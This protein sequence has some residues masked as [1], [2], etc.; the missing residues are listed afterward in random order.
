MGL[1]EAIDRFDP[2]KGREFYQFAKAR[3][4]GA[5]LDEIRR[6]YGRDDRTKIKPYYLDDIDCDVQDT[7]YHGI[8]GIDVEDT[9]NT[10]RGVKREVL[11]IYVLGGLP[12]IDV[13]KK[14]G[15]TEQRACQIKKKAIEQRACQIKKKAINQ[16]LD[17][18]E[19]Y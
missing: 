5:M 18:V 10:L 17:T 15:F 19:L 13:G 16:L 14:L 2:E 6:V 4:W 12:L 8:E 9:V 1:L 7:R 11:K 3:V